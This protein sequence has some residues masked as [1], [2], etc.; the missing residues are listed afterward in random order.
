VPAAARHHPENAAGPPGLVRAVGLPAALC[1]VS[2]ETEFFECESNILAPLQH[3]MHERIGAA[4][5]ARLQ[6]LPIGAVAARPI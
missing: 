5:S 4:C 1:A 6:R 3:S 2:L